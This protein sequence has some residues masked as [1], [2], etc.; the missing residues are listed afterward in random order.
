MDIF[1]LRLC[2]SS[3]GLPKCRS[4]EGVKSSVAM[5]P[6]DEVCGATLRKAAGLGCLRNFA[7]L[8]RIGGQIAQFWSFTSLGDW[9]L[10]SALDTSSL[11]NIAICP[12]SDLS[13]RLFTAI[14][15]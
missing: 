4:L 9:S 13:I 8:N 14:L 11:L 10:C 7:P 3:R 12:G 15:A 6:G 2:S 1:I 5:R